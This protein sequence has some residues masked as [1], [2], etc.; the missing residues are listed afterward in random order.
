MA[1]F[2]QPVSFI[3]NKSAGEILDNIQTIFM[4]LNDQTP[5]IKLL[6]I[7]FMSILMKKQYHVAASIIYNF[8][9]FNYI[10]HNYKPLIESYNV[11]Y[12]TS[13]QI[14]EYLVYA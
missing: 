13:D 7:D 14:Y 3:F 8:K 5:F 12:L 4:L 11:N 6:N 10:Y 9:Y 2:A 1:K